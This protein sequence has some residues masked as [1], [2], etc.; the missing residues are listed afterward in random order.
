[1]N[2]RG[3][4]VTAYLTIDKKIRQSLTT[5]LQLPLEEY[6]SEERAD[7]FVHTPLSLIL[8]SVYYLPYG[9]RKFLLDFCRVQVP[10]LT[11][12][13]LNQQYAA[14]RLVSPVINVPQ[15]LNRAYERSGQQSSHHSI[16]RLDFL[17]GLLSNIYDNP[18]QCSLLSYF[19]R[20]ERTAFPD[21]FLLIGQ[22]TIQKEMKATQQPDR[23]QCLD[24]TSLFTDN[25]S[26]IHSEVGLVPTRTIY[27]WKKHIS[28]M[29]RLYNHETHLV[30]PHYNG[31]KTVSLP[32]QNEYTNI[33]LDHLP[34]IPP[35][36]ITSKDLLFLYYRTGMQVGGDLEMRKAW[37]ITDLKPRGYYCLGGSSFW[38]AIYIKDF[39]KR[40]QQSLPSTHPDSRYNITRIRY[41]SE[42][43][44]IVTYD[45]SAFT[46]SLAELKYFVSHL[47]TA[48]EGVKLTVLDVY[49]G[50]VELDL[51]CLIRYSGTRPNP[52]SLPY[53]RMF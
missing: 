9:V 14:L 37:F 5:T 1:M 17:I 34:S 40:I 3:N 2:T 22:E 28:S 24:Y 18:L 12:E 47:A 6:S 44:I 11:N 48:F 20:A 52:E 53:N 32:T 25:P 49:A 13:Y 4:K 19:V 45:Y 51:G 21:E 36:N 26:A 7:L 38:A 10:V 41:I 8:A 35:T 39:T 15:D 33:L 27:L 29:R 31:R 30:F 16:I 46:T 50:I 23:G 43:E 42:N